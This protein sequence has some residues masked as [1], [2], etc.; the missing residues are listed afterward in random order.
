MTRILLAGLLALSLAGCASWNVW[1][2]ARPASA[3]L[4]TADRLAAQGDYP[5][6]VA[7]YDEFLA[8]WGDDAEAPRVRASRDTLGAIL[9]NRE[10]MARLRRELAR[11]REDLATREADLARVRQEAERLRADLE[12]LKQIDLRPERRGKK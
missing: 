11:L 3:A 1:P 2:F 10:E 7:A 6:A 4:A 9:A 5:A 12:R 8:K